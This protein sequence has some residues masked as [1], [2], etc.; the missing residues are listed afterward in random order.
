MSRAIEISGLKKIFHSRKEDVYAVGPLDLQINAGE[1]VSLLG[2]S[3]CGKSTL[4]MMIAGL[5]EPT[6]GE[7]TIEN[8]HQ[9]RALAAAVD[10]KQA[11][12]VLDVTL[13]ILYSPNNS[14]HELGLNVAKDWGSALTLL[15]NYQ[16]LKT[17]MPATA[18]FT[19]Q[20]LPSGN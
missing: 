14:R 16:G 3:G 19:N 5:V 8:H 2:P 15:K 18:F 12:Q 9:Q 10:K 13:S 17:D 6:E 20:F 11:L 7:V 1:F 4:L